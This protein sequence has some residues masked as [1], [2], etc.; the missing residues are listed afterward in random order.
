MGGFGGEVGC[1]CC[2]PAAGVPGVPGAPVKPTIKK[3]A[4]RIKITTAI[5]SQTG[6]KLAVAPANRTPVA[7]VLMDLA[8]FKASI[9]R[10]K[11]PRD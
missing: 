11:K 10:L 6:S 5:G 7:N 1:G 9:D 4:R 3:V 8:V 2:G